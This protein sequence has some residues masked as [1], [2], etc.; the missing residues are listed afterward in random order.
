MTSK[1]T[2]VWIPGS[3]TLGS[4]YND[5]AA[6][7]RQIGYETIV[8]G[9]PSASRRP[10]EK[11]A[12]LYDDAEFYRNEA[13]KLAAQGKDVIFVGH[14]YGGMVASEAAKGVIK[15]ERQTTGKQGGLVQIVYVTCVVPPVGKS[16]KDL[17]ASEAAHL[18]VGVSKCWKVWV[19]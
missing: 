17:G 4:F 19:I 2:I 3:F 15:S 12:T 9:L 7:L 14:S 8:H 16:L 5:V 18:E 6:K 1:P 10:P 11:P 13:E